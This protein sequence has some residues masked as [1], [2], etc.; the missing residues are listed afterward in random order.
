MTD[1]SDKMKPTPPRQGRRRALKTQAD[2]RRALAWIF[3]E[4]EAD[5]LHDKRARTMIYAVQTL[6]GVME[7]TELEAELKA[8]KETLRRAGHEVKP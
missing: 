4:L 8:I 7:R 3:G 2:C 6:S 5:R 1:S